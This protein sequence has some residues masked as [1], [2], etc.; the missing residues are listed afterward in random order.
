M[1]DEEFARD[2]LKIAIAQACHQHDF[3]NIE[4]SALE[5]LIDL[6]KFC[7]QNFTCTA[8]LEKPSVSVRF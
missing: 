7:T 2:V 4:G 1:S 8:S 3:T 6:M 5:V